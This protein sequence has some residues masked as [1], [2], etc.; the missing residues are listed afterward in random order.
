MITGATRAAGVI[1]QPVRHSM[2]PVIFNA[3]FAACGLDWAYLAF[4]VP[5][6]ASGLAM[7]GMRALGLDG[8]SVTMPHKQAV[9]DALDAITGLPMIVDPAAEA[10]AS[11]EGVVFDLDLRMRR[12]C[13]R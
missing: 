3:A 2:S 13:K 12:P 7:A 1:G 9:I 5:D 8:L 10:A 6:G 4:E 11:D